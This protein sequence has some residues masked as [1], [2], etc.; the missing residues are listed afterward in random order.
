[1]DGEFK[2]DFENVALMKHDRRYQFERAN[3]S[4]AMPVLNVAYA[5]C[6]ESEE[7]CTEQKALIL[8]SKIWISI[9]TKDVEAC[10][11]YGRDRLE[12]E[13]KLFDSGRVVT[14]N[15]AAAYYDLAAAYS[16]NGLP[17]KAI[18]LLFKSKQLRESMPAFKKEHNFSPLHELSLAYWHQGD[19][20]RAASCLLEALH[21]RESALGKDDRQ[22]VRTGQLFYALGNVRSSQNMLEESFGWHQRALLHYRATGGDSHFKTAM[23]CFRVAEHHVRMQQFNLAR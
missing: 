3:P 4:E 22:S 6:E 8:G 10:Y 17:S 21:D 13:K 7:D 14:A 12:F 20:E 2:Q 19:N 15:L 1:M 23:A 11:R 9:L 16:M 5:I 18:P